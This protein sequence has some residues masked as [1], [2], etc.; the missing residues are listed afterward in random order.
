MQMLRVVFVAVLVL[1]LLLPASGAVC[2]NQYLEQLAGDSSGA[3]YS[4][5]RLE[6]WV[7]NILIRFIEFLQNTSPLFILFAVFV[8]AGLLLVGTLFGA[9]ALRGAGIA[10]ILA[11]VAA[12]L[13]IRNAPALL[14]MIHDLAGN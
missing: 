14:L 7:A 4:W 3:D 8:G 11:A 1:V 13:I 6:E 2:A 5:E 9:K 12:Y 10:G